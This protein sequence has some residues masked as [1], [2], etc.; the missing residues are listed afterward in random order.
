M[1]LVTEFVDNLLH[2]TCRY[3]ISRIEAICEDH[4][5]TFKE[6][7]ESEKRGRRRWGQSFYKNLFR[8]LNFYCNSLHS[9]RS[10]AA[11]EV[12]RGLVLVG[13]WSSKRC[14]VMV[15]TTFAEHLHTIDTYGGLA[16]LNFFVLFPA[17]SALSLAAT[18]C[19]DDQ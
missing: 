19:G 15:L 13:F 12:Y 7:H 2:S 1:G 14:L 6:S 8:R 5:V 4:R 9:Y 3:Q 11:I 17:T 16:V 10:C 18:N